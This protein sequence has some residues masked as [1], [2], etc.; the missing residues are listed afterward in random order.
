MS[1]FSRFNL[2]LRNLRYF[3]AANF[4][5][6]AGMAVATAVLTG[7]LMVGDSVRGSLRDMAQRRLEFVDHAMMSPRFV[8][9]G[10]AKRLA[11]SAGFGERFESI[12]PGI[13]LRGSAGNSVVKSHV[14]GVQIGALGDRYAVPA[15]QAVLNPRLGELIDGNRIGDGHRGVRF[16]LPAPDEAPRDSTMARRSRADT[17]TSFSVETSKVAAAGGFLDLFNLTGGQRQSPAAWVNL[18][19]LQEEIDRADQV[20]L[21]LVAA[22]TGHRGS[23][24]GLVESAGR[25]GRDAGGLWAGD[26]A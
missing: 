10:L 23:R 3:R 25:Q 11:N 5:V 22:K 17:I 15:D 13:I 19:S 24:C 12:T 7:A 1:A 21:F 26:A 8:D 4:A 2:L 20:N 9:Q 18:K 16:S 6:I 14:A